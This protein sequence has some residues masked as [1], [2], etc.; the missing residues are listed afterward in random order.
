MQEGKKKYSICMGLNSSSKNIEVSVS[1]YSSFKLHN[2]KS[3]LTGLGHAI[4]KNLI[5]IVT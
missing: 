3:T 1:F 2:S 5:S 4:P